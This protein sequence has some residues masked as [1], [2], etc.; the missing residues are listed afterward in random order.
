[1]RRLDELPSDW[2]A[3]NTLRQLRVGKS[4]SVPRVRCL[5]RDDVRADFLGGSMGVPSHA[6]RS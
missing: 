6:D 2:R 3:V 5:P 4:R 1:M